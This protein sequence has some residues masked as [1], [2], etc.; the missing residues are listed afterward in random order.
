MSLVKTNYMFTLRHQDRLLPT[1]RPSHS[2][3]PEGVTESIGR[4]VIFIC[5]NGMI[6]SVLF[7]T[8][9]QVMNVIVFTKLCLLLGRS[10]LHLPKRVCSTC[11]YEWTPDWG[12]LIRS[13][14]WPASVNR[15]TL[16]ST[17][18]FKSFGDLKTVA[19]GLSRQAFL[20]MLE[21]RTQHY[22]RDTPN[23]PP[24]AS[25]H[26]ESLPVSS[27]YSDTCKTGKIHGDVFQRSFLEYMACQ[28]ECQKMTCEELFS[29]PACTPKMLAVSVDGN[30]KQ[31]RFRQSQ[32]IDEP[33]FKGPFIM[34]DSAVTDFVDKVRTNCNINISL[35]VDPR[36]RYMLYQPV[37][38]CSRD[39]KKSQQA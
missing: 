34:E 8:L 17:D 36:K 37:V 26:C 33:L 24:L 39:S 28:Y 5:I 19:P 22:G 12:D 13:G 3:N 9:I 27:Y 10:D 4:P 21:R 23:S 29:C 31:Y 20:Q 32:R 16:Y 7:V 38:S 11:H 6:L 35:I 25:N 15:D 1:G 2:C 14:Y 18:V 30:R